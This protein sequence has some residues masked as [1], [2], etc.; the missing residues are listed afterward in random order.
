MDL[1]V[2]NLICIYIWASTLQGFRVDLRLRVFGLRFQGQGLFLY[3]LILVK[4]FGLRV[5]AD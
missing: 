3:I 1:R 2:T 4:V 5:F